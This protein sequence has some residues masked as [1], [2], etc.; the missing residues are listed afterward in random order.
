MRCFI[1]YFIQTDTRTPLP[2][3]PKAGDILLFLLGPAVVSLSISMFQKRDLVASNFPEV[4]A[5]AFGSSF[6]GLLVTSLTSKSLGLKSSLSLSL[7]PRCITTPL[8]IS[9]SNM[10][11]GIPSITAGSVVVTGLL[12]ANFGPRLLTLFNIT[13]PTTRGLSIGAAS[14]GLGTAA[15]KGENDAFPFA[16]IAMATVGTVTTVMATVGKGIIKRIVS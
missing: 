4:L 10:L 2:I 11:G 15:V 13:E 9:V 6:L 3:H 1:F 12:G 7:A 16:A 14:H 5:T 8:A